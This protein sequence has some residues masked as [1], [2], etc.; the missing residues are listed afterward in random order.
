MIP[1]IG[2]QSEQVAYKLEKLFFMFGFPKTLH[3]D[4]GGEFRNK[5]MEN[6]CK[7]HK[8]KFVHGAPRNPST[9]GQVERNNSSI[10]VNI[11][12]IVKERGI[13]RSN[14]CQVVHEAAY[15]KKISL[16][17]AIQKTSYYVAFG[18]EPNKECHDAK[19]SD[20]QPQ[21]D[22]VMENE[23]TGPEQEEMKNDTPINKTLPDENSMVQLKTPRAEQEEFESK[24]ANKE[25][26]E[27]KKRKAITQSVMEKQSEYNKKMKLSR[28]KPRSFKVD[29]YV[30]IIKIDKVDKAT[31]LHPN[32]I[33]GKILSME[34]D[35]AKVVTKFGVISTYIC[36]NRLNKCTRT[37]IVFDFSKEIP[38]STVSKKA[39]DQ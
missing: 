35:Y 5:N 28:N 13:L 12:N 1:L 33:L 10:K 18:K 39:I 34:N 2:K 4:K 9:Q 30:T 7:K 3:S 19:T 17:R 26:V 27:S 20:Q 21:E 8:I 6:L 23:T 16:H 11:T 36:T 29:D 37:N 25:V 14:W 22:S 32:V 24:Q 38:F 31:P 15:K